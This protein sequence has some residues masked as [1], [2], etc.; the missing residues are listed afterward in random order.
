MLLI[1]FFVHSLALFVNFFGIKG[2]LDKQF[3]ILTSSESKSQS[4]KFWPFVELV[5]LYRVGEK[6]YFNGVFYGYDFS[7]FLAYSVLIFGF[8]YLSFLYGKKKVVNYIII[9]IFFVWL[10]Y[11]LQLI[12]LE[13]LISGSLVFIL[14][15][16]TLFYII[17][18]KSKEKEPIDGK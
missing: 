7:E 15:L 9:P 12:Y 14:V 5:S 6:D 1:W 4:G 3:N 2:S 10:F 8:L 13:V 11:M 16:F 17:H 18:F